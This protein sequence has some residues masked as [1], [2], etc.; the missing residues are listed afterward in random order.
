MSNSAPKVT[1]KNAKSNFGPRG[2]I[3]IILGMLMWFFSAS[4]SVEGTNLL[5]P[6]FSE[7]HS[8][9]AANLYFCN[10]VAS[11]ICVPMVAVVGALQ[12]RIG[13]RRVI[14]LCWLVGAAGLTILGFASSLAGYCV[15]RIVMTVGTTC[16]NYIGLNGIISNW[17]PTK[18]D[19]VLGYVTIGSN[20]SVAISLFLL[21]GLLSW[22]GISFTFWTYAC[23]FLAI[24][25]LSFLC[26]RSN[27]EEVG[28][29]PDN[30]R[31]MTQEHVQ[32]LHQIGEEYKKSSPWT[33][34][35]LLTTRQTWQIA[36]GYGIILLITVGILSTLVT[37]LLIK[38]LDL[39]WAKSM[40]TVAAVCGIPCSYLWGVLG[41]K[42]GT[43]RA[44]LLLYGVAM[45]VI[46][47]MLIPGVWTAVPVV[48]LLGCFIG[49][50]N[51]LTPAIIA[52]VYGRY[53]FSKALS[54]ILPIW[55]IVVAFANTVVG[56]PQSLTG[57][58]TMSYI[59]LAILAVIGF[60]LVYT[61][62]DRC[63]GRADLMQ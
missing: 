28:C 43:K 9:G 31:S 17:F 33:A 25:L 32:K 5:L 37:S 27:P 41:T 62:N 63:I 10:T 53:D 34:R 52:S 36:I 59:V 60:F 45:A 23:I 51:N 6:A 54:V 47:F 30:D 39:T 24:G 7:A 14:S 15:G 19:L 18:K 57:S 42:F 40:M 29:F 61:L 2:W 38:G 1:A 50:G 21:N 16:G 44:T 48:F 11:L 4:A 13:P 26:L 12:V 3:I 22:G 56:V 58:Y 49:A 46:V 55:N 8:I 35:R 20:L